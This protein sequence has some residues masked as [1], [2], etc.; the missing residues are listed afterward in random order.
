MRHAMPGSRFLLRPGQRGDVIALAQIFSRAAWSAHRRP[1]A[2][3][4]SIRFISQI[5]ID[6]KSATLNRLLASEVPCATPADGEYGHERPVL[7][8]VWG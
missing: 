5:V 6:G 2:L 1:A 7:R 3:S 8:M 4:A